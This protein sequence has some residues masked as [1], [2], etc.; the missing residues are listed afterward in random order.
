MYVMPYISKQFSLLIELLGY[1]IQICFKAVAVKSANFD[2]CSCFGTISD[3][4]SGDTYFSVNLSAYNSPLEI[5]QL[6]AWL[7]Y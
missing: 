3:F 2:K 7:L 5:R 6:P 4:S 1:Y